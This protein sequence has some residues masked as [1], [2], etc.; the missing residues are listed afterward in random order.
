MMSTFERSYLNAI[1]STLEAFYLTVVL[2]E[3]YSSFSIAHRERCKNKEKGA[4]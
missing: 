2:L 1:Y 4:F 3:M